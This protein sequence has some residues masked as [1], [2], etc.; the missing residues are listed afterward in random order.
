MATQ[1]AAN[2]NFANAQ[3]L[4]GTGF[5]SGTTIG[6]SKETG[7]LA[8]A[9]NRGG[10]SIWFKYEAAAPQIVTFDTNG[11]NFDTLLAVYKGPTLDSLKLIA[12]NDDAPT[13]TTSI[14]R[15]G[16]AA[17]DIFY[18]A[19]DG[20]YSPSTG[21]VATGNVGLNYAQTAAPGNDNFASAQLLTG[22][23]GRLITATNVGATAELGDPHIGGNAGGRSLWYKWVAP[24][25]SNRSYTFTIE[26]I[27]AT[28]QFGVTTPCAILTGPN[29]SSLT[30][31]TYN[32]NTNVNNLTFVP[33]PGTTYYLFL[34]GYNSGSGA[35]IGTFTIGYGVTKDAKAAD[36]DRDGRSDITVFRPSTGTWYTINSV[37]DQVTSQQFGTAGDQPF[38]LDM[39]DDGRLDRTVYRPSTGA[40]YV[41]GT[42]YGLQ[43]FNWGTAGDIPLVQQSQFFKNFAVFRPSTSY[44]YFVTTFG[45]DLGYAVWGTNGDVPLSID[46]LGNGGDE[47][48]VFRPSTGTWY[49]IGAANLNVQFGMNGD[50]PVPADYDGDGKMDIAVFRPSNGTWYILRSSDN[51]VTAMQWG[52][53]GDIPQPADYD[54]D[55]R[56]DVAVFRGGT[57]YILPSQSFTLRVVQFGLPGDIPVT[58]PIH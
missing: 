25:G 32:N 11:S 31:V 5:I 39:D 19:V 28:A 27:N 38:L 16:A 55:G 52:Q 18:V 40:W 17:G 6:A 24:S 51:G 46:F 36:F 34:D 14:V 54:G 41:N 10:A 21:T 30:T 26:S 49:S 44:W 53:A 45:Y 23:S 9:R 4:F 1:A 13:G 2:D 15:V 56:S 33:T 7:E 47:R 58:A 20:Y 37:T 57:W 42:S 22:P 3:P 8:H 48:T 43:A 50:K 29:L 12:A 35:Q